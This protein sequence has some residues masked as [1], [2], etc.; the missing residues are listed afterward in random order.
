MDLVRRSSQELLRRK[1]VE[2]WLFGEEI[3]L[4]QVMTGVCFYWQL[5]A[6]LSTWYECL[7]PSS[8]IMFTT[9]TPILSR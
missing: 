7:H 1:K 6:V 2:L 5:T 4:L 8:T 9:E 3:L